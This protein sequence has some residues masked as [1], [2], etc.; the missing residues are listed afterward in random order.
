MR[1]KGMLP[2]GTPVAHKTGSLNGTGNDVGVVM[3]PDGR[4]F[5]IAVFVMKDTNGHEARDRIAAEAARAAYDYFL[6]APDRASL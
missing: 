2:A 4:S 6:F 3:L 5:A 1:I